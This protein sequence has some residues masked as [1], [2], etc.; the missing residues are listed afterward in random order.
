MQDVDTEAEARAL[1]TL[2]RGDCCM[3]SGEDEV[4]HLAV[5]LQVSRRTFKHLG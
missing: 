5:V 3:I 1:R 4:P 2:R